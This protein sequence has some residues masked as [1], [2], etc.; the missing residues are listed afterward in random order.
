MPRS[1]RGA[2]FSPSPFPFSFCSWL[3]NKVPRHNICTVPYQRNCSLLCSTACISLTIPLLNYP[4]SPMLFVTESICR[5]KKMYSPCIHFTSV[6][7]FSSGFQCGLFWWQFKLPHQEPQKGDGLSFI[8][9]Q[10]CQHFLVI[11]ARKNIGRGINHFCLRS[12]SAILTVSYLF[13][14]VKPCKTLK[15]SVGGMCRR[16][17]TTENKRCT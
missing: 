4:S 10:C 15:C 9:K 7:Y 17:T 1:N 3:V 6:M 2:R 14:V 5:C 13:L 11:R 12:L 8:L 16:A